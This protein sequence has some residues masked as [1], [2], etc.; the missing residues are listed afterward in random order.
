MNMSKNIFAIV[1]SP[2]G[3]THPVGPFLTEKEAKEVCERDR[4]GSTL[5]GFYRT[6]GKE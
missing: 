2:G 4:P 5:L 1:R 6:I 3:I